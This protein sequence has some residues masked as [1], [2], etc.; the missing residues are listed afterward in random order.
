MAT[1]IFCKT[2]AKGIQKFFL[3]YNNENYAL[4]AQKYY[5]S[6]KEYFVN[7]VD[8]NTAIDYRKHEGTAVIN[9]KEKIMRTISK[10]ERAEGIAVLDKA[11]RKNGRCVNHSKRKARITEL[12][13]RSMEVA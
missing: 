4:F 13:V 2:I 1:K 12:R 10:L 11:I 5:S 8:I 7:G 9:T 6:V 3:V